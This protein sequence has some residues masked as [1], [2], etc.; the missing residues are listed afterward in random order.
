MTTIPAS[1]IEF[2]PLSFGDPGGRLFRWNGQLYRAIV[3]ERAPF[4]RGLFEKG[5]VRTLVERRLLVET[6][7]T[8]HALDGYAL[9]LQH[10]TLPFISYAFEWC[11]AM[12]K[13]A[14][15]LLLDLQEELLCHHA[16]LQDAHPWNILFDG[17]QPRFVDFGSIVP[18]HLETLWQAYNQFCR[19]FLYPLQ[20]MAHGHDRIARWLLHDHDQG[21]QPEEAAALTGQPASRRPLKSLSIRAYSTLKS[22]IPFRFHKRLRAALDT[23]RSAVPV[24][25]A[26]TAACEQ[27]A[28]SLFDKLRREIEA[29]PTGETRTEWSGYYDASFPAFQPGGDWS[30]KHRSVHQALSELKPASVLDIG[31][32]RGWHAQLA[33]RQGAACVAFDNDLTCVSR[34]YTDARH[35]SLSLLPL[36]GDFRNPTPG[37]GLCNRWFAPATNRLRCDLVL[38]LALVHHLV[39]K[40]RLRFDQVVEGISIFAR[41]WLLVE[42][43]PREDRYVR[44]WWSE[45]FGWYTVEN[46]QSALGRQFRTI[47]RLPSAPE[48]RVLLLC[49]K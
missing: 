42:F 7:V 48:P 10:R 27:S 40:Q 44:E 26:M 23:V 29:V 45:S 2:H 13:D 11:P 24:P 1:E 39:F 22:K 5:L 3:P 36:V 31:S 35:E 8:P 25:P 43:V 33:A 15:L 41:R 47:R 34:L 9:V 18:F 49:E 12:L 32:N 46:L 20:I 17:P 16:T 6:E 28:R 21:V 38:T 30:A 37:Y 14:A 19:Y 4:Y